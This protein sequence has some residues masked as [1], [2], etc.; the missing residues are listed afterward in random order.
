MKKL[1]R[2]GC[3]ETNSSSSHSLSIADETKEFVMDYIYPN[4]DGVVTIMGD[5]YGWEWFK[6][7]DAETKASYAAQSFANDENMLEVLSDVIKE[8][9]GATEVVFQGLDDGYID[10]DSYG[11]VPTSSYELK[12]FIFNKNSWLFGGNDNSTA[13]PTFYHVPEFR[14]GKAITPT[15]KYELSIDGLKRSTKFIEKPTDEEISD[16]VSSLLDGVMFTQDGHSV[17]GEGIMW[18]ITRPRGV[19]YEMGYRFRQ[20]YSSG[21]LI[22]EKED[23]SVFWEISKRYE[24]SGEFEGLNYDQKNEMIVKEIVKNHPDTFIKVKFHL[25]EI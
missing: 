9:T 15:Y 17:I 11:I 2:T 18:Q 10:H 12:N 19:Y 23:T 20:N 22:L 14:D 25:N 4:Q 13:D 3:F 6:H 5:E 1:I 16:A 24:A 7:N 8:Q 21:E